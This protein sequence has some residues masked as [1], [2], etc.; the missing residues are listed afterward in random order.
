MKLPNGENAV[1]DIAKL[2]DYCLNADHPEGK[3]KARAFREKLD[4][5]R[6]D[7]EELRQAILKAILKKEAVE[8]LPTF[9][10]RRFVVDFEVSRSEG[11][12]LLMNTV[13]IRT[14]W[15]IRNDEDFPRLTTCFTPRRSA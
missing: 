11:E 15:M 1:V 9:Y 3:H 2:R 7:A 12:G 4:I 10:G 5:G 14:A 13:M 6:A 8:Q